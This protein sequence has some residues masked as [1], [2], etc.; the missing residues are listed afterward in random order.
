MISTFG[1]N[2]GLILAGARAYYAMARD[3]LFFR[4]AG[5]LNA[6]KVPAWGLV[7]QGVWAAFLVLPRTYDPATARVRQPLQQPARLRDLG[8]ADLLHPDDR[9]RLPPAADAARR[10]AAVPRVRLPGRAGALH[11][12]RRDD[13]ARAVRLPAGDDLAGAGHR[14]AGRAGVFRVAPAAP[15]TDGHQ[16]T[17]RSPAS[18]P[19]RTPLRITAAVT[20][21]SRSAPGASSGTHSAASASDAPHRMPPSGRQ[22]KSTSTK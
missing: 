17:G 16:T 15:G 13:P 9:R 18:K 22:T 8:G 12:R 10:R 6:A 4:A 20:S 3:G 19:R 2:N 21:A 1:C 5:E 7:L 11:R 14:A